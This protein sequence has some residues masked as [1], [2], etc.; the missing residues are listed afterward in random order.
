MQWE[1]KISSVYLQVIKVRK[2]SPKMYFSENRELPA[3]I[4]T[5]LQTQSLSSHRFMPS[6]WIIFISELISSPFSKIICRYLL[7]LTW[8]VTGSCK[9]GAKRSVCT[10]TVSISGY[11]PPSWSAVSNPGRSHHTAIAHVCSHHGGH[12]SEPPHR[13]RDLTQVPAYCHPSAGLHPQLLFSPSCVKGT[14]ISVFSL[15]T[16]KWHLSAPP[17]GAW[18][19]R[20]LTP[21]WCLWLIRCKLLNGSSIKGPF[22]CF[23]LGHLPGRCSKQPCMGLCVNTAS[24]SLVNGQNGKDSLAWLLCKKLPNRFPVWF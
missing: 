3:Y 4:Y 24:D 12:G 9:D 22:G 20:F 11:W 16:K 15:H 6:S 13:H 5:C 23:Q 8:R 1:E 17:P 21:E 18:A 7:H 2:H 10:S 14:E 19:G